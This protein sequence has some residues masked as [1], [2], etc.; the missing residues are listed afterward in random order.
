MRKLVEGLDRPK[1][2]RGS[3]AK[4]KRR[5]AVAV[6]RLSEVRDREITH[7]LRWNRRLELAASLELTA[8]EVALID[9][10]LHHCYIVNIR[11][12]SYRMRAYQDLL[13]PGRADGDTPQGH[14]T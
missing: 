11:S 1:P 3:G 13:R 5:E 7:E 8:I 9:R 2:K 14:G 6:R 10:L 12:N 4:G